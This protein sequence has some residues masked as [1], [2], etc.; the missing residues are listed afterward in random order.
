VKPAR[1]IIASSETSADMLYATR[2]RAP[3]AFVFLES[4]GRTV[5]L[6]SDLELDRGRREARVD[7]VASYSELEKE[8]QHRKKQKPAFAAVVGE[9]LKRRGVKHVL[10]PKDF[11]LGLA[12]SLRGERI[13]VEAAEGTFWPQRQFKTPQEVGALKG[14]LRIAEA[15]MA[16]GHEILRVSKAAKDGTLRW[17]GRILSAEV[18]RI[19]MELA[20]VRAGG[21]ARGDTIVACGEAACD[22]HER[23]KGPLSA[24]QLIILDIFP[25]DSRS[26]YFGDLTRT[27]VRGR[28]SEAQRHLWTTC[29]AGQERVLQALRPGLKGQKIHEETKAFFAKSGYPTTIRN[30][31]WSGFF[32][33][34]GHSLGL[35]IHEEPR[36]AAATFRSGQVFTV[37][38]GI[39]WPGVGGVRHEDVVA[40]TDRGHQLMSNFPKQ[41]EL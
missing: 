9:F 17:R 3:D 22:P 30:G 21:E 14:A 34:T 41:L 32:H 24:N 13:R 26:G 36:F 12:T 18:L 25:R 7:E 8:L 16:R 29:L 10:T 33:G 5:L 6:L 40:I 1:L 39:Y 20:V 4:R 15:G 31:R 28:A 27:V 35:E 19:E 2:F 11:P 23:G 38:P 37:E